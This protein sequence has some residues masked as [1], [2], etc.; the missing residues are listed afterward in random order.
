MNFFCLILSAITIVLADVDTNYSNDFS[1]FDGQE[2]PTLKPVELLS[3]N[4]DN[5]KISEGLKST[6]SFNYRQERTGRVPQIEAR[7]ENIQHYFRVRRPVERRKIFHIRNDHRYRGNI[8]SLRDDI[9]QPLVLENTMTNETPKNAITGG[10]NSENL[11]EIIEIV[12][13]EI[14]PYSQ[15]TS[16]DMKPTK[17]TS[18][19]PEANITY[20]IAPV[21]INSDKKE[22]TP[23]FERELHKELSSINNESEKSSEEGQANTNEDDT[24]SS[25]DGINDDFIEGNPVIQDESKIIS[26]SFNNSDRN[27]DKNNSTPDFEVVIKAKILEQKPLPRLRYRGNKKFTYSDEDIPSVVIKE[28]S[29]SGAIPVEVSHE[30]SNLNSATNIP[31]ESKV[32][33]STEVSINED[34]NKYESSSP[35]T[36]ITDIETK[37]TSITPFSNTDLGFQSENKPMPSNNIYG[38]DAHVGDVSNEDSTPVQLNLPTAFNPE[39]NLSY[40]EE[41]SSSTP[42]EYTSSTENIAPSPAIRMRRR[43]LRNRKRLQSQIT[44]AETE[45]TTPERIYPVREI[46]ASEISTPKY[47][48]DNLQP[49]SQIPDSSIDTEQI[50]ASTSS[51]TNLYSTERVTTH[52]K[53]A[54][55]RFRPRQRFSNR[56]TI[57]TLK[58]SEDLDKSTNGPI[59]EIIGISEIPYITRSTESPSRRHRGR[60]KYRKWNRN[61]NII[62]TTP[63]DNEAHSTTSLSTTKSTIEDGNALL[64]LK[65]GII[66]NPTYSDQRNEHSRRFTRKRLHLRPTVAEEYTTTSQPPFVE[67]IDTTNR[68]QRRM[69]YRNRF[70]RIK[71]TTLIPVYNENPIEEE[72]EADGTTINNEGTSQKKLN[73]QSPPPPVPTLSPWF[74]GF[75]K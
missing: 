36:I 20:T 38:E 11:P 44:E 70:R 35:D 50:A 40:N 21:K 16:G 64:D 5:K 4:N 23:S 65:S 49:T 74:D 43:K 53:K 75:G 41:N 6:V 22:E 47:Y 2:A 1:N 45:L 32:D 42:P 66:E 12:Q 52:N 69:R 24:N 46:T 27:T 26:D 61:R 68:P 29:E 30:L 62:S 72:A 58:P 9:T 25:S 14:I 48:E 13:G 37:S 10:N 63:Y 15:Q 7:K 54:H 57:S 31:Q 8:K 17:L 67:P 71:T 28:I 59:I 34:A 55:R 18:N 39:L 56:H 33:D 51:S 3:A 60:T 73:V 19:L